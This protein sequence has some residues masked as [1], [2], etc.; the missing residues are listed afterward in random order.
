M[1]VVFQMFDIY[2][3]GITRKWHNKNQSNQKQN[4]KPF[5]CMVFHSGSCTS[6]PIEVMKIEGGWCKPSSIITVSS[7]SPTNT[8]TKTPKF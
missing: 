7:G 4:V 6:I 2:D 1:M 3:L 8:G 5:D